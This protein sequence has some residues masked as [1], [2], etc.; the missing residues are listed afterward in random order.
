MA[1]GPPMPCWSLAYGAGKH[2]S[3]MGRRSIACPAL[4]SAF[5]S[6]G[7]LDLGLEAAGFQTVR[8]IELDATARATLARNHPSW[9]LFEP[10]E[11]VERGAA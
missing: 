7:G 8:C 11:R 5:S 4:L 1:A 9:R 2:R 6:A 10:G 3:T